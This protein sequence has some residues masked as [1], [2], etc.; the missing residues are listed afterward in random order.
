MEIKE[1]CEA[2]GI[3]DIGDFSDGFH[4]FNQLYHQRAVLFATIVNNFKRHAWK[5]L[6]HEDGKYCF[7]SDGKWFIVG[8]DTPEGSYTYHYETDKYWDMFDCVALE[9]GKHW[10]GHTEDDVTRLLSIGKSTDNTVAVEPMKIK[11]KYFD[12]EITKI[13]KI[14][15]GDLIDLRISETVE[16]KQGEYKL[17][18][19][20]IGMK[21][22]YGYEAHVYARSSTPS[23]FGII[24]ANSVGI[25]DESYCGD[26]D[27]WYAP[28]IAIRDTKIEKDSRIC[29]FRIVEHQ[30][31]FEFEEVKELEDVS[32]GGIGST[33]EK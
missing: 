7:D 17:L 16:L 20:G 6:K 2:Y 21:L 8:V 14:T 31:T 5:S 24:L 27:M 1:I 13:G 15:K 3:D 29:Q 25:I 12:K 33:G 23:K 30:P 11:I 19:L 10:D 18:P 22:P 32:R 26:N 28:V 4:T 9:C